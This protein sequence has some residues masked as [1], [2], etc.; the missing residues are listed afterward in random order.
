MS[1]NQLERYRFIPDHYTPTHKL[2]IVTVFS[3][4]PFLNQSASERFAGHHDYGDPDLTIDLCA[5][6]VVFGLYYG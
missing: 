3:F 5:V 2:Y 6:A 1:N 4:V